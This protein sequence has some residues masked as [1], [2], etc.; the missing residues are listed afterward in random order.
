MNKS[1]EVV[2]CGHLCVDLIPGMRAITAEQIATPGRLYFIDPVTIATGGAVS[3]TGLAL[4]KLGV[5]VRLLANIGDDALGQVIR[6]TLVAHDPVLAENLQVKSGQAASATIVLSPQNADR[7]FLHC[8]GTNDLFG[9]ADVDF[10]LVA[11]GVMFHL[12]YPPLLPR[13]V[14][15]D[16]A[17]LEAIFRG[18]KKAGAVTSLDMA[19]PDPSSVIARSNWKKIMGRVLP[20]MDI[21]VPSIEETVLML[22]RADYDDWGAD[23]LRHVDRAYLSSLADEFLAHGIPITGFKLGE[24]GMYLKTSQKASDY[25]AL[26]Q[27][28]LNVADWLGCELYQPAYAVQVAGTTGAGDSAYAGFLT[29]LLKGLSPVEALRYACAVGGCN[30]EAP[31]ATSGIRPWDAVQDRLAAGWSL[32]EKRL[33]G[34]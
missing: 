2:V 9:V 25:T 7:T 11:E 30:V 1:I 17:E 19:M 31:D 13:L 5:K 4:H 28:G 14:Q 23:I 6:S 12:G 26:S 16:G 32:A 8:T 15:H 3:N 27:L 33:P 29:S 21:F 10:D 22:R 34:F 18:A 20:H 24:Y